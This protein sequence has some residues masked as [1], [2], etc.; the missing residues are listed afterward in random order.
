MQLA[1]D[2]LRH[3]RRG[4]GD[5]ADSEDQDGEIDICAECRRR[6]R[7]CADAAEHDHIGGRQRDLR[8]IG[9]NQRPTEPQRGAEF[10]EPQVARGRLLLD[11]RQHG[12]P[13]T[14]S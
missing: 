14:N 9:Q 2:R 13:L 6:Q 7:L 12:T 10:S 1:P 11:S 8:E 4:R 5:N 3:H